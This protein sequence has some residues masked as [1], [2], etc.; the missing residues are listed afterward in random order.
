M[1]M[2]LAV[3]F[4]KPI[5]LFII[6]VGIPFLYILFS[7]SFGKGIFLIWGLAVLHAMAWSR[8]E[9]FF[10]NYT[11]Y[12][13]DFFYYR[14]HAFVMSVVFGWVPGCFISASAALIRRGILYFKP[15]AF[16]DDLNRLR[17]IWVTVTLFVV[18][19]C[20]VT[21]FIIAKPPCKFHSGYISIYLLGLGPIVIVVF[22]MVSYLLIWAFRKLFLH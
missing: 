15:A 14:G 21:A 13:S 16:A 2:E 1:A 4:G 10:R 20:F 8:M 12:L 11:P 22:P 18:A 19:I 3:K 9:G 6:V 17:L 5:S 7:D